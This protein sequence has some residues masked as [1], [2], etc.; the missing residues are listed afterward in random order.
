MD[1]HLRKIRRVYRQRRDLPVAALARHL[2]GL[3]VSGVAA[4]LH[5]MVNLPPAIDENALLGAARE[6][7]VHVFGAGACRTRPRADQPAIVLGYGCVADSLI[8][9]GVRRLARI[10]VSHSGRA[11]RRAFAVAGAHARR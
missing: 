4:G 5:L 8:E 1:R 7:S 11:S 2:P 9:E 3:P 10:I 6:Q